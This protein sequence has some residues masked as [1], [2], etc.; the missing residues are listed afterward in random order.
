[1]F[2]ISSI[3]VIL[4]IVVLLIPQTV[5]SAY[6]FTAPPR[7]T[8]EKG[9][10]V[11]KPIADFLTQ[12]TGQQFEYKQQS[13]WPEYVKGMRSEKYDLVFDGPHFVDWRIHNIN[14]HTVLK[15]PHLLQW[16]IITRKNNTSITKVED[17]V[18]KKTC[19]PG[20]PN[21]GM[22]NLFNHFKDKQKQP[23][24]VQVKGWKNVFDSVKNGD[25]VAGVLPKKNHLIYDKEGKHTKSIHTHLPYPNQAFTVGKN[26]PEHMRE[27]I[28]T[29]L[30]SE[31]GQEAMKHLRQRYTGGT[32]L[33]SAVNEEYDSIGALLIKVESFN[34]NE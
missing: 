32:N 12:A 15:I 18:G 28:R 19:A 10:Q 21:F 7:E 4:S 9:H 23:V 3:R 14:H 13:T 27:K 24:H 2:N 30:L 25:C 29:A 5:L 1:M 6:T 11:Y 26:I 34:R 20:S 8:T 17:L 22:L 16:R 33:V 31:E